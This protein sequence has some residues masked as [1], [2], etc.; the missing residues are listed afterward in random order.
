M[1][2]P[3]VG[4]SY[5]PMWE[6]VVG[7]LWQWVRV[8]G[9]LREEE[10]SSLG[11]F[12]LARAIS[13]KEE[14][15]LQICDALTPE[16]LLWLAGLGVLFLIG[17]LYCIFSFVLHLVLVLV[18]R[19]LLTP[20]PQLAATYPTEV[21]EVEPSEGEEDRQGLLLDAEQRPAL[22]PPSHNRQRTLL[23][24]EPRSASPSSPF[25]DSDDQLRRIVA[26]HPVSA[27]QPILAGA[28][29]RRTSSRRR[30]RRRRS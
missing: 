2:T 23:D 14:V 11:R 30:I 21:I 8:W 19:R 15:V 5:G 10:P 7:V 24:A 1:L 25:D 17:I 3:A 4:N 9:D 6:L 13:R 22:P 28:T 12:F 27:Q 18:T 26:L 29:T 16:G 20:I